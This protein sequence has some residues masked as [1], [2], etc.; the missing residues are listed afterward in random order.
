MSKQPSIAETHIE[1]TGPGSPFEVGTAVIAGIERRVWLNGPP[2]TRHVLESARQ[3]GERPFLIL[4]D[5]RVSFADFHAAVATLARALVEAGVRKGDRVAIAMRNL[6]E[7]PVIFFAASA[8]GG[9]VVPLNAWWTGAEL[10][11][12][13]ADCTP[14]IVFAD[15]ERL[16]RLAEPVQHVHSP[17]HLIAC[18][19]ADWTGASIE[20]M[21]GPPASW[22]SLERSALPECEL[23]TDD[24]ATIFYTSGTTGQPKGALASHRAI[25]SNLTGA[26]FAAARAAL[27][28]GRALPVADP[29][30]PQAGT[31]I[32]IP[33]FHVTGTCAILIPALAA[34]NK[35]VLMRRWDAET[36]LDLIERERLSWV[37][38]VP[39]IAFQ[40]GEAAKKT[41]RDLSSLVSVGYGGAAAAP[42]LIERLSDALPAAVPGHGWGMTET[43]GLATTHSGADYR[44]RPTSCGAPIPVLDAEIRD[45]ETG[46]ALAIGEVGELWV[47]GPNVMSGYWNNPDATAQVLVNGWLRTGDLARLDEDDFLYIVDRA[48]DVIIRGGENIHCIEV[49]HCLFDHPAVLDA[50]LVA[51]PDPVLGE[52]PAAVVTVS[53]STEIDEQAL[54]SH[55][56]ERLAAYKVPTRVIVTSSALPRNAAGKILRRELADWFAADQA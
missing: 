15:K 24:P 53:S 54:R 31:L 23:A 14:R 49:E 5:E 13:I 38:G 27:R 17:P 12:A 52:V 37:V 50:A 55:V 46:A 8:V 41:S 28:E 45:P 18:R 10:G 40:L 19:A 30:A 48:K 35:L 20:E 1:L 51:L 7:W 56:A 11:F 36:A 43:C 44:Q 22:A 6:P 26:G 32:A 47:S 42:D 34:G 39:T 4:D 33:L 16:E 3:H 25:L 29:D 9:I 2:T 21:I